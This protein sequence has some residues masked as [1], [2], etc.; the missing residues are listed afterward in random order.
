ME[1]AGRNPKMTEKDITLMFEDYGDIDDNSSVESLEDDMYVQFHDMNPQVNDCR[2]LL[3]IIT[4]VTKTRCNLPLR[5][6]Y[7]DQQ[8]FTLDIE[9]DSKK[10]RKIREAHLK[11]ATA[12]EADSGIVVNTFSKYMG[13]RIPIIDSFVQKRFGF[14]ADLFIAQFEHHQPIPG[15][16]RYAKTLRTE[17]LELKSYEPLNVLC[18]EI[19]TN[20]PT[21]YKHEELTELAK[22]I[23]KHGKAIKSHINILHTIWSEGLVSKLEYRRFTPALIRTR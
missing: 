10:K 6:R 1:I 17:D 9:P 19:M 12:R 2:A 13:K 4:E 5:F 20:K 16:N 21:F 3:E 8:D 18:G 22:V 23:E 15:F 11:Q 7:L 14:F